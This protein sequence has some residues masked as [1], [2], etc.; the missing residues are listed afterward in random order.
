MYPGAGDGKWA[1]SQGLNLT[2]YRKVLEG[3]AP[4]KKRIF[5]QIVS[6]LPEYS[7]AWE[8]MCALFSI[9]AI[10]RNFNAVMQG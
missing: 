7:V 3:F 9:P 6:V 1:W 4:N 10:T 8:T 2:K 5:E